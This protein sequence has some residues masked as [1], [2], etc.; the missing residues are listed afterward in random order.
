MS[1]RA[2][3]PPYTMTIGGRQVAGPAHRDIL[4]PADG[5]LVGQCPIGTSTC[6]Q[7]AIHAAAAAQPAWWARSGAERRAA[8]EAIARILTENALRPFTA[9]EVATYRGAPLLQPAAV[10]ERLL[11]AAQRGAAAR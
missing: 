11:A 4:N 9:A 1:I 10:R 3:A 2:T 5:S 6:L 7:D 8:C